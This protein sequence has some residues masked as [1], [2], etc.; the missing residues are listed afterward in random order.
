MKRLLYIGKFI[1]DILHVSKENDITYVD[2]LYVMVILWYVTFL[3]Q[4]YH[5]DLFRQEVP[6]LG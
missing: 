2:V 6:S 1:Q 4:L 5:L 3:R